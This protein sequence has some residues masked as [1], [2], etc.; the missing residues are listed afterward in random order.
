[1]ESQT[2]KKKINSSSLRRTEI[3]KKMFILKECFPR[4][5]S[6]Q[7]CSRAA[8]FWF[9]SMIMINKNI[10]WHVPGHSLILSPFSI[11]QSGCTDLHTQDIYGEG[12]GSCRKKHPCKNV[13]KLSDGRNCKTCT[14]KFWE[15]RQKRTP[16]HI[17]VSPSLL[18]ISEKILQVPS[19]GPTPGTG[20]VKCHYSVSCLSSIHSNKSNPQNI[21]PGSA[22]II[23]L[24]PSISRVAKVVGRLWIKKVI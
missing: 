4:A 22:K 8:L 12:G 17:P 11:R 21:L 14:R 7:W 19:L 3:H 16:F 2:N 5:C 20:A 6:R 23:F 24:T 1:M 18:E 13:R 9:H 15:Q 10:P